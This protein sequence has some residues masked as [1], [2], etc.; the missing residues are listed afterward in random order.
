MHKSYN[1]KR[2]IVWLLMLMAGSYIIAGALFFI[3]GDA[4]SFKPGETF[5]GIYDKT[6]DETQTLDMEGLENLII[7]SMSTDINLIPTEEETIR[8]HLHGGIPCSNKKYMPTMTTEANGNNA[9]IRV[10]WP[11][12]LV[13]GYM[14]SNIKLDIYL[15]K[16]YQQ[17]LTLKT[18]S[19]SIQ[20]SE[21]TLRNLNCTST[22]GDLRG[23]LAVTENTNFKSSSGTYETGIR[24]SNTFTMESTSGDFRS[25][26]VETEKFTR[27]SSAGATNIKSLTCTDF[28]HNSTSGD[29]RLD[30]IRSVNSKIE[31][32][33]GTVRISG[34]N[35][36]DI[37]I[38]T[39]SGDI[40]WL[41]SNAKNVQ[42]DTSSGKTTLTGLAGDLELKSSSGDPKVQFGR[43][44]GQVKIETTS[45]RVE[46]KLPEGSEFNLS[47]HTNSGSIKVKGFEVTTSG[48][49]TEDELTGTVGSN[50]NTVRIETSSGDILLSSY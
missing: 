21:L 23:V 11:N 8:A 38:K 6:I 41:D 29:L 16:A 37:K 19:A 7:T 46:V 24:A 28:N 18:S 48:K 30:Y 10:E 13:V 17:D 36:G 27:I 22:S 34:E 45:G 31:T 40:T 12:V 42:V 20:F 3:S 35:T 43:L 33:S 32:S 15:P 44:E 2:I 14:M 39:T 25:G 4:Q 9:E 5:Q 26:S 1:I 50:K 49:N 47:C